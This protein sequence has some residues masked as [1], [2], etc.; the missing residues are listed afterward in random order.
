MLP[1]AQ[2]R[3]SLWAHVL[4]YTELKI[5]SSLPFGAMVSVCALLRLQPAWVPTS[6]RTQKQRTEV[7]EFLS[8][9]VFSSSVVLLPPRL[10]V[11]PTSTSWRVSFPS[12]ASVLLM[13]YP[14]ATQCDILKEG[15]PLWAMIL[16]AKPH[17]QRSALHRC[18]DPQQLTFAWPSRPSLMPFIKLTMNRI[19]MKSITNSRVSLMSHFKMDGIC[20]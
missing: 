2:S 9:V 7:Q 11:E 14:E 15:E 3:A 18:N 4:V 8:A 19:R 13:L 17:F 10:S 6:H 20:L 12:C 5:Y 16:V 1:Q